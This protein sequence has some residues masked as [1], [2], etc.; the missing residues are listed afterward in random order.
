MGLAGVDGMSGFSRM[1]IGKQFNIV[2]LC[3]VVIPVLALGVF[4]VINT[5]SMLLTHHRD[6]IHGSNNS[7]KKIMKEISDQIYNIS[8]SIAYDSRTIEMLGGEYGNER[9]FRDAARGYTLIDNF[10]ENYSQIGS[11]TIYTTTPYASSFK[12]FRPVTD[13][14]KQ[15]DWYQTAIGQYSPFY[16]LIVEPNAYK[17]VEYSY[18][19]VRK[20]T[21]LG[22]SCEAV[23]VI[24]ISENYL[25]GRLGDSDYITF[26]SFDDKETFY[27]SRRD[28][29]GTTLPFEAD[30]AG[31]YYSDKFM[32]QFEGVNSLV[33][34][35]SLSLKQSG[36]FLYITTIDK[37][38]LWS[39]VKTLL[40]AISTVLVALFVPA[41]F[42]TKF[43]H[44]FVSQVNVLRDE[45]HKASNENYDII[46][47]FSGS[48][49]LQQ[50]YGDLLVMVDT[51]EQQKVAMYEAMLNEKQLQNEQQEMEFKM[52]AS[53]INPH[54]LYNTLETLRMKAFTAG[55]REVATGIKLLGK[56]LRYVLVNI[57]TTYT[58]LAN[59]LEHIETYIKI[60]KIRFDDRVNY[61]LTV[62]DGID[63]EK[64][65]LLPLLLQPIVENAV[66]HGLEGVDGTGYIQIHIYEKTCAPRGSV[67][68]DSSDKFESEAFKK[69]IDSSTASSACSMQ[70][71]KNER[72]SCMIIDV[73][74]NG[75]GM[76]AEQLDSVKKSMTQDSI[77]KHSSIGMAN[78]DQRIKLCY[79]DKY[80]IDIQ[81]TQGEGTKVT[82]VLPRYSHEP[83]K[84]QIKKL[85]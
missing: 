51:I 26:V 58:T 67:G 59:E 41:V 8:D 71:Y 44:S 14:I 42:M 24:K 30:Y 33:E 70:G 65:M 46:K 15:K 6:L 75:N 18:A 47:N 38:A 1:K 63:T 45:M 73:T 80:G 76:T 50:A 40:V 2:Y 28:Y 56:M 23:M 54:F 49:E 52:L 57:G 21:V 55:D 62:D 5:Y 64:Y 37:N 20:I 68:N 31:E 78:I 39:I 3:A 35:S 48:Y 27:S 79:G 74:D 10:V 82:V 34:I 9:E 17:N 61:S 72:I 11:I 85:Q 16:Q 60:Q 19:L 12:Y 53:Q 83:A 84:E 77:S 66:V 29:Y 7:S 69:L 43:S 36:S 13:E 81:S 4:L 22:S 25:E 32:E